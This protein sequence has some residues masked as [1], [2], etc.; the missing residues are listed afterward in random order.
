MIMMGLSRSDD[1]CYIR[2]LLSYPIIH[3]NYYI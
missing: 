3:V 1:Y 2:I